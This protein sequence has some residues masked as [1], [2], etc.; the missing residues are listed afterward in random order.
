VDQPNVELPDILDVSPEAVSQTEAALDP[1]VHP[2]DDARVDLDKKTGAVYKRWAMLLTIERALRSTTASK[3]VCF[4]VQ[5][6][7]RPSGIAGDRTVGKRVFSRYFVNFPVLNGQEVNPGHAGMNE[8]SMKSVVSLIKAAG[9][10]PT[11]MTDTGLKAAFLSYLFPKETDVNESP[12]IGKE[13]VGNC[14][15]QPNNSPK[16]RFPRDTSVELWLPAPVPVTE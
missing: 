5:A 15:E 10:A 7:V 2:P 16:A 4:F 12:L 3:L 6:R 8:R 14:V 11:D 9:L 13:F 1:Q